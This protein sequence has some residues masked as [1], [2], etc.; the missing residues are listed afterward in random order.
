MTAEQEKS[1]KKFCGVVL[2]DYPQRLAEVV[3]VEDGAG[4]R[5]EGLTYSAQ[6]AVRDALSQLWEENGSPEGYE[7]P[8]DWATE[9]M[10][11]IEEAR[12]GGT[13][14]LRCLSGLRLGGDGEPTRSMDFSELVR[15]VSLCLSRGEP[16]IE[17]Q[18]PGR[19]RR[20]Q[21]AGEVKHT[22]AN[23]REHLKAYF[24]DYYP[25][26][27]FPT[28]RELADGVTIPGGAEN[29]ERTIRNWEKGRGGLAEA[30]RYRKAVISL[31]KRS[32][33]LEEILAPLPT[34]NEDSRGKETE[35]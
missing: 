22:R 31:A 19:S 10:L 8:L 11:G 28:Q 12:P 27:R 14:I 2:E 26:V 3:W 17:P 30:K 32:V 7:S 9:E 18:A 15:S 4:H 21:P 20:R 13:S 33:P 29:P 25:D 1:W 23:L 35:A 34:E 24:V 6:T 5:L 16:Q